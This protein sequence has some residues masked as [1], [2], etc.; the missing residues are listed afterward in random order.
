[1][2]WGLSL[3][4]QSPVNRYGEV[5]MAR[6][7]NNIL[8]TSFQRAYSFLSSYSPCAVNSTPNETVT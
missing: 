3:V 4:I 5:T 6:H 8:S 2:V 1:M 7:G